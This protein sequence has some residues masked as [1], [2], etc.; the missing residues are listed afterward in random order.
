MYAF[1]GGGGHPRT[2]STVWTLQEIAAENRAAI[3]KVS[4]SDPERE[5][6]DHPSDAETPAA[7]IPPEECEADQGDPTSGSDRID[8]YALLGVSATD[9]IKTIKRVPH[10]GKAKRL[11]TRHASPSGGGARGGE[12]LAA[13]GGDLGTHRRAA[14]NDAYV[15]HRYAYRL[16]R[17]ARASTWR[18]R[19][20]RAI[21]PTSSTRPRPPYDRRQPAPRGGTIA[22][23][24]SSSRS[25]SS[26]PRSRRPAGLVSLR[27]HR[28]WARLR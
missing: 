21:D 16:L 10:E 6:R 28:A 13:G 25:R 26:S 5:P 18:W 20:Q 15:Q 3:A 23:R 8:H 12:E 11:K 17:A 19:R 22:P 1:R 14:P 4:M 2:A 7:G 9:D 27:A 24:S